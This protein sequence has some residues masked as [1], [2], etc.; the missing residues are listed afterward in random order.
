MTDKLT[1]DQKAALVR[2][3]GRLH[4]A[5]G[6]AGA[7]GKF[8]MGNLRNTTTGRIANR[9]P[10]PQYLKIGQGDEAVTVYFDEADELPPLVGIDYS[11]LEARVFAMMGGDDFKPAP[12]YTVVNP[13]PGIA[14]RAGRDNAK[15]NKAVAKRREANKAA[16]KARAKA[17]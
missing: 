15:F 11:D 13:K 8:D 12:V 6:M 10:E 2:A 7:L 1:P 5:A 16:R 4:I 14:A 17:R 9:E 3:T